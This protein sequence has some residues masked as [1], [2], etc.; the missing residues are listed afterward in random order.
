MPVQ[1]QT[2]T[3]LRRLLSELP[4]KRI[5]YLIVVILASVFQG[6]MDVLLVALLARVVGLITGVKLT[7]QIPGIHFFGGGVLDQ[8]GW[9][10][11]LLIVTFWLTSAVRFGVA[12]LQS[13]LSAEIW[14]DLVNKVYRNLMLQDYEFFA[15]H[16]TANLS[17]SFNRI[18]NKLSES[19]VSPVIAM[20]SSGVS[21]IVLL[22]GVVFVLG[23]PA[24]VMFGLLMVAYI[25]SAK[26]I[27]PYLRFA[28][29][30]R[31]RYSRRIHMMLVESLRSM[32]DVHLYSADQFFIGRFA[33][34]SLVAKRYDKLAIL[35]PDVPRYLIEPAGVSILFAVCLLP[36]FFSGS[37]GEIRQVVPTLAAV[38]GT[39]LRI[40]APLHNTFRNSNKLRGGLPEIRDAL[41]LLA[42]RPKRILS[43]SPGV[44]TSHGIMPRQ[45][46]QLKNVSYHYSKMEREILSEVNITIPIGSRVALVG[47]TGSGK[48]TLINLLL[49]LFKPS[50]G[51]LLLDGVSLIPKEVP[52]WQAN[53]ALVPQDIV[54][55]DASVR[56]NVAFGVNH[57]DIDD[58]KVW[59]ALEAAQLHDP[60]T[61]MN[62]GLYTMIGE[63]GI[64]LSGG[65]RQRLSLA[66]AFYKEA[67]VLVLDEATSAL[68]NKTED[69][70]MQ[71]LDLVG[72]RCTTIVIAHRLSTIRK[73]D[74]I[75]E[76]HDGRIK[77]SGN[78][79][80][81]CASSDSFREMTQFEK[82]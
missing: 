74:R 10:L 14:N 80:T 22:I 61:S 37:E 26:L 66:R 54:L 44:P 7:D 69:E 53:C 29:K 1:S 41:E 45:S 57:E 47:R 42:L 76:V 11:G 18:L 25:L 32:R 33:R 75:Y 62:Y 67:K 27:I 15:K 12:Y 56:E 6:L 5:R 3:D 17:E 71:A 19:I 39:L 68:D 8:A 16:R 20:T 55:L 52:A 64:K 21:V 36:I 2:W 30:Q 59:N 23:F 46:I 40:S 72:R 78:F 35:L 51:S 65:Q 63:N 81:L 28:T 38:L 48:T 58:S 24:L 77:A 73:C 34:D 13:M 60:V 50:S 43:S 49:G 4:S 79:E 31:M 82:S 70:V 9:L